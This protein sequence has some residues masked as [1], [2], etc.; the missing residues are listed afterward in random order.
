MT[1]SWPRK[2]GTLLLVV[3]GSTPACAQTEQAAQ[4]PTTPAG[5]QLSQ[6]LAAFNSGD[7]DTMKNYLQ[8]NFPDRLNKLDDDIRF[9]EATGGFDFKKAEDSKPLRLVSIENK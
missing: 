6:L 4:F 2:L 1:K 7:K 8:V 5:Q 3:A 9:R